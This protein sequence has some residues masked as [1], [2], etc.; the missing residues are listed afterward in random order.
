MSM[1][2]LPYTSVKIQT[3]KTFEAFG[4]D[5]LEVME[6]RHHLKGYSGHV[7]AMQH[8]FAGTFGSTSRRLRGYPADTQTSKDFIP[9]AENRPLVRPNEFELKHPMKFHHLELLKTGE[10]VLGPL[11]EGAR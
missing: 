11:P 2:V 4:E 7:H 6:A 9:F 10:G 3:R 5:T 1:S 8:L